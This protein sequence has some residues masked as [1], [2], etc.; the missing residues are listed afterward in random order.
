MNNAPNTATGTHPAQSNWAR[1]VLVALAPIVLLSAAL[2]PLLSYKHRLP[3]RIASHW[4]LSGPADGA[5][6]FTAL[7]IAVGAMA[8]VAAALTVFTAMGSHTGDGSFVVPLGAF[9]SL[10]ISCL[11]ASSIKQTLDRTDWHGTP[12]PAVWHFAFAFV[13]ASLFAAMVATAVRALSLRQNTPVGG[14]T[15]TLKVFDQERLMWSK[16]M[17]NRWLLLPSLGMLILAVVSLIRPHIKNGFWEPVG[18]AVVAI[19][20]SLLSTISVRTDS[21]GLHVAYGP[22][23]W[24]RQTIGID[25]IQS[26]SAIKIRPTEWGGW[27]Y[28]GSLRVLKR[29][30]VVL[31]SGP[32]IRLDLHNGAR[33]AV[34]ITDPETGAAVLNTAISRTVST[35]VTVR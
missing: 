15:A 27:G 24:P 12:G 9:V 5:T 8:L 25:R 3:N 11:T 18:F 28:R 35:P 10:L 14:A 22:F 20:T 7:L 13:L 33:F 4:P 6:S 19:G 23:N 1:A 26:A 29:A 17:T 16:R 31:R 34:T 21:A 32:G 2:V 30:A